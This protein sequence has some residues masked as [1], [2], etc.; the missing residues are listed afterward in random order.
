MR[1]IRA[2]A[3]EFLLLASLCLSAAA[4]E[5]TTLTLRSQ[6]GVEILWQGV[7]IGTIEEDGQLVIRNVP[8]GDFE[9]RLSKPGY[10]Y[11]AG[12]IH[13]EG[14]RPVT[15]AFA[16]EALVPQ[17]PPGKAAPLEADRVE[18]VVPPEPVAER[19]VASLPAVE[20]PMATREAAPGMQPPQQ[21][22]VALPESSSSS[23]LVL[24]VLAGIGAL[25]WV[26][27]Q[28]LP[29]LRPTSEPRPPAQPPQPFWDPPARESPDSSE[30][31]ALI[32][33]IRRRER[34]RDDE[35]Q[36]RPRVIEAEFVELPNPEE[37]T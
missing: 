2:L 26:M 29:F 3:I 27:R 31:Q 9:I 8:A 24:L 20:P 36:G 11:R 18:V 22:S 30:S 33:E 10:R 32:S 14:S 5:R 28:K 15:Q 13:I 21:D 35:S 23:T 16:L 25:L 37:R 6:P 1:P 12:S 34:D 4:Q 7:R 19:D 17:T